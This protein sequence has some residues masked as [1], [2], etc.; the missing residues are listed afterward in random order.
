ML[1][2]YAAVLAVAFSDS[3]DL[4]FY[5]RLSSR[6]GCREIMLDL[7]NNPGFMSGGSW[8]VFFN[9]EPAAMI[10]S[11]RE[12]GKDKGCVEVVA[13]APR[14]RRVKVGS[15]LVGKA[16]WAFRDRRLS[17]VHCGVNRPNRNAVRFFRSLGFQAKGSEEFL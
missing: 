1:P 17:E 9:R 11:S 5:N 7:V 3:S 13:V 16:L 8:L 4:D 6:E 15:H 2:A 12:P 14:H 10:I